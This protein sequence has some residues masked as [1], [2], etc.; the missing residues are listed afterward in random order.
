MTPVEAASHAASPSGL[1]VDAGARGR[2]ARRISARLLNEQQWARVRLLN[3]VFVLCLAASIALFADSPARHSALNHWIA[4]VFPLVVVAMLRARRSPDDRLNVTMLDTLTYV[5]GVVSLAAMLT[6]SVQSIFGVS[7]PLAL[8]PRLWLFSVVYLGVSRAML[9]SVRRQALRRHE[10]AT[11]TL[12]VGAGIIGAHLVKRLIGDPSYGLRPV[13]F[14]DGDPLPVAE[15]PTAYTLPV[16]GGL[17]DLESVIATTGARHVILAFSGERDHQL[18][19]KVRQCQA[20][21][22]GVSLV[23]RLYE[24]I[25]ERTTLDHVG[26]L[27]M[28]TLHTIDPR[29][30]QFVLKHTIDRTIALV[31]LLV[32]SPLMIA[33]SIAVHLSSPGPIWFR[34]RR[35]GRDGHEFDVLKFRTMREPDAAERAVDEDRGFEL[36]AGVAPGGVEGIDRRTTVGRVLRDLSL[37]ELP[38]LINVLRGDMSIVGPRPER[39]EYVARFA[40]DVARYEDR[41]RV[42]SGITGWAQANGLRG[43][44]SIADRVEWDNYYIQNWSLRLDLRIILL[45]IAEIF[46]SRDSAASRPASAA[47]PTPSGADSP[48][49]PVER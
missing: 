49:T 46:R 31:V 33:I 44:T 11:P 14:L 23:P 18:M 1:V 12:I 32:A 30:W 42:K 43:Q 15:R 36:P 6:I 47:L 17:E 16:L 24:A 22:V 21:G 13:G 9:V 45:T 5:L 28:L 34:Q 25:N 29:G 39:P 38:Q 48:K 27:P 10:L 35:V 41:H 2:L 7:D 26:G 3:D 20:L 4:A 19:A 8:V 40:R 37:D